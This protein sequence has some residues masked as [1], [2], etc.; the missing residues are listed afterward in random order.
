M[1]HFV[2]FRSDINLVYSADLCCCISVDCS[3]C[4]NLLDLQENRTRRQVEL[5]SAETSVKLHVFK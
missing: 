1:L 4:R 2:Y 3:C 5:L